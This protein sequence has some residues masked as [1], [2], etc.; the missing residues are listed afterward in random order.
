MI[1]QSPFRPAPLIRLLVLLMLLFMGQTPLS[2]AEFGHGQSTEPRMGQAHTPEAA[3]LVADIDT[4]DTN[5]GRIHA[6]SVYGPGTTM[7]SSV[8]GPGILGDERDIAVTIVQP[9]IGNN[10]VSAEVSGG[11]YS[12]SQ[13]PTVTSTGIIQWDGADSSGAL[14]PTGLGHIDLTN[15]LSRDAIQLQVLFVDVPLDMQLEIYSDADHMSA[16]QFQ[17]AG[18][19][20]TS[21][22]LTFPLADFQPV[23]GSGADIRD[24]GAIVLKMQSNAAPDF[25]LGSIGRSV[26]LI[27]TKDNALLIDQDGDGRVSPGDVLRYTVVLNNEDDLYNAGIDNVIFNDSPGMYT[28]LIVGSVTTSQGAV[29]QGNAP[30][31]T[32]VQ[33]SVGHIADGESQTITFDVQ[34]ATPFPAGVSQITNQGWVSASTGLPVEIL[35][36]DPATPEFGDPTITPVFAAPDFVLR[37]TD[38]GISTT[39]GSLVTYDLMYENRGNQDAEGAVITETVPAHTTFSATGSSPGWTCAPDAG[40]GSTCTYA[41]ASLPVA[42]TG[43]VQFAVQI[44]DTLPAGVTLI[45]NNACLGDNGSNGADPNPDDNC[46]GDSTPVRAAPDLRLFKDD[47]GTT[48]SPGES[49]TYTITVENR[50]NQGA[51]GV[52]ITETVPAHTRFGD[53]ANDWTCTPDGQAGNFCTHSIG[54]LPADESRIVPFTVQLDDSVAAGVTTIDNTACSGD[55]GSNGA[56]ANAQDN[57]SDSHTPLLAAPDLQLSK[58]DGG[59]D[60]TPGSL[61]VYTLTVSNVGD[62]DAEGVVITETVPA[63]S[64][65]NQAASSNGWQCSPDDTAGSACEFVIGTLV[66]GSSEDVLFA[67][68]VEPTVAADLRFIE[69]HA[70]SS[71]DG[72]NGPDP[73]PGNNCD[74]ASTS[75]TARPDLR[76]T[77]QDGDVL[78]EPGEVLVYTLIYENNGDRD[79]MGVTIT[80][81]VPAHTTFY[82]AGSSQGWACTPGDEAGS[83]CVFNVGGLLARS[84]DSIAFAVVLDNDLGN[85]GPTIDNTACLGANGAAGPDPTPANNCDTIATG[86]VPPT[87]TPTPTPSPT[88]TPTPTATPTLTPTSTATATSTPTTTPTATPSAY[89]WPLLLVPLP[90][91]TPTAT[92]S[93]T[94]TPTPVP[95]NLTE[96]TPVSIPNLQYPK[97]LAVDDVLHRVYVSNHDRDQIHVAD[98]YL[99][100]P[101]SSIPVCDQPFGVASNSATHKVYVTC[102][103]TGEVAVID[104]I[105]NQVLK[106]LVVGPE[107]TY[108]GVNRRTN[109]IYVVTHGNNGL[110]EID[111][112]GDEMTRV[113]G[114][115]AGA[116][117][118]AINENL[119][120]IYVSSRDEGSIWT[121]DGATMSPL[122][123]Q[124]VWPGGKRDHP[125]GLGFNPLSNR[126]YATYT[127]QGFLTRLAV[128]QTAAEGLIRVH[129]VVIPDGGSDAPGQIGVNPAT[130]HVFTLNSASNSITVI[131]GN[132]D[133]IIDTI[134]YAA[135]PFAIAI[136]GS[137]NRLYFGFRSA[138]QIWAVPDFF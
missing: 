88:S 2:R 87:S 21:T 58:D 98:G 93:P 34:I 97:G 23:L 120:R 67:V 69:N 127:D 43:T 37:K 15:G 124:R 8:N 77:K 83:I 95:V 80:E 74:H 32:S 94:R 63:A 133:R 86:I 81:T 90:S 107:P 136:D 53:N 123:G 113:A 11:A 75:V 112:D 64:T 48:V 102:F 109:R 85:D 10:G 61:L 26:I 134:S 76:L 111:G 101:I 55:D 14:N 35:T 54:S 110:V 91:P 9:G 135:D 103:A 38:G 12:Y 29:L 115:G 42:A 119:N 59:I 128:Y 70:C 13:D 125:Y 22:E 129:T 132:T 60:I 104:A 66:A 1:T 118:L 4:F 25:V 99:L 100:Q 126:L 56:D 131:D 7:A 68:N 49:L 73:T 6:A 19:I 33:V 117:G 5:Q 27:P 30:G 71:D 106:T 52:V 47:G 130:N 39:T 24:V 79:A 3:G 16:L 89:Y 96:A 65:F 121:I 108:V 116:F 28:E 114:V 41:I 57:C 46:A 122:R 84:S 92:P 62:Q 44:S 31:D 51:T 137:W 18:G 72:S 50:G 40:S 45:Q 138:N 17:L 20:D 36:D 105:S 82:A 78:V